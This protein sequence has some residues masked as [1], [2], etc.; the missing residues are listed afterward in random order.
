LENQDH[1]IAKGTAAETLL[2]S[3]IFNETVNDLVNATFNTF[4]NTAQGELEKREQAYHHY[5]ALVDIV[6]TLQQRV[7]VRDEILAKADTDNNNQE[8]E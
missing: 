8:D 1:L 7:A 6:Q 4:T 2:A 5:R 3:D